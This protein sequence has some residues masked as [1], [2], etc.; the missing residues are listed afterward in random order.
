MKSIAGRQ[1]NG[2]W[3][4]ACSTHGFVHD[5]RFYSQV[6]T[7]PMN[8][9]NTIEVSLVNWINN[10]PD[11]HVHIDLM[12]WPSNKPCSGTADPKSENELR[13]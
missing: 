3:G 9:P 10:T 1:G 7:I 11:S 4:V 13:I 12:P 6:Y 5:A 8:S 2:A